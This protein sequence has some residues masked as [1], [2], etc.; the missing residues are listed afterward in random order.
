MISPISYV[1]VYEVVFLQEP[2]EFNNTRASSIALITVA[3][4]LNAFPNSWLKVRSLG[5]NNDCA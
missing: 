1:L 4:V 5:V 3:S 2:M